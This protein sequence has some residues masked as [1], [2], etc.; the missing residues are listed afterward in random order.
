MIL[1]TLLLIL[2][3]AKINAQPGSFVSDVYY[4]PGATAWD[5]WIAKLNELEMRLT[6]RF[7]QHMTALRQRVVQLE[8]EVAELRNANTFNWNKSD[9]GS[10]YKVFAEKRNFDSAQ[11]ACKTFHAQIAVINSEHK[12]EYVKELLLQTFPDDDDVTAWIGMRTKPEK[13]PQYS[14]FTDDQSVEGCAT[15]AKNGKWLIRSCSQMHPFI[16]QQIVVR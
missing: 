8:D 7:K 2:T 5:I 14:N 15:I 3:A 1:Y 13:E 10:L 6:S 4:E 11:K 16:C 9:S 12:N